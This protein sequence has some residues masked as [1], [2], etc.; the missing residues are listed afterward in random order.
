MTSTVEPTAAQARNTNLDAVR[1][2]AVLGILGMNAVS[3]GLDP[4]AYFNIDA[5]GSESWLDWAIGAAGE[6]FFDQKFMGLFSL[7]FGAGIVLFAERAAARGRRPV[8][9]SLWRNGLL[10]AIGIGHTLVWDGDILVVYALCAPVLIG[11]RRLAPRTLIVVG[12]LFVL[13]SAAVAVVAQSSVGSTGAGVGDGY[14][15]EEGTLSD[16][17]GLWLIGDFF[18]R[19]LGMMLIGV[20][21]YR[22]G[23]ITGERSDEYYRRMARYG[24][25]LGV[26]LA[27]A[28]FVWVAA[29]DFSGGV[30]AIGSVP[31]TIATIPVVLGYLALITLWNRGR[32]AAGG[33]LVSRVRAAGRMALTNYLAQTVLGVIILRG[34]FDPTDL[35]RSDLAAFILAV[36]AVELWWSEAWLARYRYGPAEWLWRSGTYRRWQP[37][38]RELEGARGR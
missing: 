36:W 37:L 13:S 6:I 16:A 24:L 35:T 17:V 21:L 34:W 33:G 4:S 38:R 1:G 23:V 18:V 14:W 31:N 8:L 25:G 27:A 15:F 20:A 26:P 3:Y 11:L 7:L 22:T 30:A 19:A 28:G 29:R 10:L 32:R 12:T 2:V 5:G 9:F